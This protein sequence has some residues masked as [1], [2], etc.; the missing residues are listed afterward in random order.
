MTEQGEDPSLA[1]RQGE[2][3]HKQQGLE[4]AF[5]LMEKNHSIDG[6]RILQL[7]F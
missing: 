7:T 1:L 4:Q 5:P 3:E 6:F 2:T